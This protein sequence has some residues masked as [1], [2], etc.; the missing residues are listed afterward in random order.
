MRWPTNAPHMAR[1]GSGDSVISRCAASARAKAAEW[2]SLGAMTG[3][4][5]VLAIG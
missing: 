5:V 3:V 1:G 2:S 4:S